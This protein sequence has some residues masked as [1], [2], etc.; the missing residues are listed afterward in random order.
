MPVTVQY[1]PGRAGKLLQLLIIS[2]KGIV[3]VVV[4]FAMA[5]IFHMPEATEWID[6]IKTKLLKKIA[7]R[8]A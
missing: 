5:V 3:A 8:R 2:A 4:Y 7:A 6:R 1:G